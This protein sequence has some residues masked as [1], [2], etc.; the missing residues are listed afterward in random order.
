MKKIFILLLLSLV[1]Q[2]AHAQS[3]FLPYDVEDYN[4]IQRLEIKTGHFSPFFHTSVGPYSRKDLGRFADSFQIQGNPIT[5][6]DFQFLN[7]IQTDNPE[8]SRSESGKR[9]AAL[10]LFYPQKAALLYHEEADFVIRANPILYGQAG[11]DLNRKE[12]LYINTR[13]VEVHGSIGKK[14]GFYTYL[15]ENQTRA[16]F[17]LRQ[18]TG[19]VGSYPSAGLTKSFKGDAFDFLQ[20]RGYITFS[21]VKDIIRIQFGHDRNFI[22]DGYRSF[23]L[24]DFGKEYLFLKINTKIWKLNYQN[25]YA[26]MTDQ[27]TGGESSK[28]RKKYLVNHHLS[29]NIL[30]NLNVGVF[31]TIV[32]DRTDSN[33]YNSGFEANYLNPVIFYRSVEHGLN[34]TDNA[35]RPECQMEFPEAFFYLWSAYTG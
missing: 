2:K 21:P 26:E 5:F 35:A 28:S 1:L 18:W 7:F 17:Y 23:I 9:K 33:G 11:R 3:A 27:Q 31:E 8:W 19:Y 15:T 25:L 24:S 20:A 10:G 6:R 16:P 30:K 12:D 4:R 22:G 32:F 34:S 14:V 29:Y 13:G